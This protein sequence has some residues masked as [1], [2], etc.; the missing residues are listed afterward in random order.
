MNLV[1]EP[2]MIKKNRICVKLETLLQCCPVD[3]H[4]THTGH[5]VL[6]PL[7]PAVTSPQSN[8]PLKPKLMRHMAIYFPLR[9]YVFPHVISLDIGDIPVAW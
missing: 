1:P 4:A 3:L 6:L 7:H 2:K 9:F 8:T 5:S